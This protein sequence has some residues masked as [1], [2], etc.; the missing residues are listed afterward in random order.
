MDKVLEVKNLTL[1]FGG[2]RALHDV[3]LEIKKGQIA[4]L[5]GPNGA[6]K[7]TLFNCLSGIYTPGSG[8]III[9]HGQMKPKRINGLKINKITELGV[10]RTFQNVRLFG[11][12][13][14][15]E[16][17]MIGRHC[18]TRA[19]IAGAVL[20]TRTTQ[21]EEKEIVS[22]SYQLLEKMGLESCVNEL[23]G[24]L[25]YGSQRRLEIARALATDPFILLLDEPAAGMNPPE[26][27]ELQKLILRLAREED[28]TILLIEHDMKFVMNLAQ[29]IFVLDYGVEIACG[30]PQ[31]IR[32]NPIVIKAYLGVDADAGAA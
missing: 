20:H 23:A 12:M 24:N 6:G 26:T 2:L 9:Y 7:T 32:N 4:A 13:T 31:E 22:K 15:L 17:V 21:N 27:E 16:N 25:P 11:G 1:N 10:A 29:R 3:S 5:I 19:G 30:N 14:V 18:R 28:L 8:D